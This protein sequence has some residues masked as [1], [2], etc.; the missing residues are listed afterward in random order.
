M[1]LPF[2]RLIQIVEIAEVFDQEAGWS[3]FVPG[4][5]DAVLNAGH[6]S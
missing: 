6:P 3:L 2:D 1:T 4:E 5:Q